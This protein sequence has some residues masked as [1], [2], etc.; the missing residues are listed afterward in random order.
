M[1]KQLA[2]NLIVAFNEDEWFSTWRDVLRILKL[3]FQHLRT[4]TEVETQACTDTH[5]CGTAALRTCACVTSLWGLTLLCAPQFLFSTRNYKNRASISNYFCWRAQ[6]H[7]VPVPWSDG[8]L[9]LTTSMTCS[10]GDVTQMQGNFRRRL[11]ELEKVK[12]YCFSFSLPLSFRIYKY[13]ILSF[14]NKWIAWP[15]W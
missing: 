15:V 12:V 1:L 7:R 11:S 14:I 2:H 5:A 8:F 10:N 13:K 9:P 6:V 3:C 4:Q